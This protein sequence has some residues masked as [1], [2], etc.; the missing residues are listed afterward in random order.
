MTW[1]LW[2]RALKPT[3]SLGRSGFAIILHPLQHGWC[4][5]SSQ[6]STIIGRTNT[7]NGRQYKNDP[8]IFAWEARALS[9]NYA[10]DLQD[11]KQYGR[12]YCRHLNL[13]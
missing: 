1:F 5:C 9:A 6:V 2:L 12:I 10:R 8:T 11:W 13:S 4:R 3:C 7:I